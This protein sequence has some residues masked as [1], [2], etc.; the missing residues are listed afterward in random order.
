MESPDSDEPVEAISKRPSV[1]SDPAENNSINESSQPLDDPIVS[2]SLF[3]GP[4]PISEKT[5]LARY[6]N[7]TEPFSS[8]AE[9]FRDAEQVSVKETAGFFVRGPLVNSDFRTRRGSVKADDNLDHASLLILDM[10]HGAKVDPGDKDKDAERGPIPGIMAMH[11]A[12]TRLEYSHFIYSSFSHASPDPEN[13]D[14]KTLRIKYRVVIPCDISKK[15]H[16]KPTVQKLCDELFEE[17]IEFENVSENSGWS[18][19]WFGAYCPDP[20]NYVFCS[21]FRGFPFKEITKSQQ[22]ARRKPGRLFKVEGE[23]LF[24]EGEDP[25]VIQWRRDIVSGENIHDSIRNYSYHMLALGNHPASVE[26]FMQSLVEKSKRREDD[27]SCR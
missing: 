21:F 10:D 14:N 24:I 19:A 20:K 11:H 25:K 22:K 4:E 3:T 16:L 6:E 9:K 17:G 13:P 1:E 7:Y 5:K 15:A 8:M 23:E 26:D 18:Q 2:Y 27:P 12:L